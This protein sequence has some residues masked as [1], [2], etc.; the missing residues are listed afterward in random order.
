MYRVGERVLYGVHGVCLIK[1]QE[2]KTVDRQ[3][4]Q[5]YVLE[6]L[7]NPGAKYY[8][9]S[10]KPAAVAKLSPLLTHQELNLLLQNHQI[11]EGTWIP[12]E[13]QRKQRYRELLCSSDR[14]ALLAMIRVLRAH[15]QDQLSKGKKFHL[16][17]DNFLR[18]AESLF[19]AEVSAVLNMTASAAKDYVEPYL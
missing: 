18:E 7:E 16:C 1:D 9:P 2:V 15:K 5:Y 11:P 3:K 17:D 12:E 10:E 19:Y 14:P 6:P 13:N 4:V 8:I